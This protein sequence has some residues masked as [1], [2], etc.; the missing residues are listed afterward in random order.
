MYILHTPVYATHSLSLEARHN[1]DH[2]GRRKSCRTGER[3]IKREMAAGTGNGIVKELVYTALVDQYI[4]TE[5]D[6]N[7]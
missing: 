7:N 6:W 2:G 5:G 4:P 3:S 1:A